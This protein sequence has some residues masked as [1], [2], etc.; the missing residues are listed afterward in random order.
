MAERRHL[1]PIPITPSRTGLIAIYL[2][3]AAVVARTLALEAIQPFLPWYLGLELIYVIL[4]T[5]LLWKPD[6]ALWLKHLYFVLQSLIVLLILAPRPQFDFVVVLFA[7]LSY[8]VSLSFAGRMRWIWVSCLVVLTGGS[9]IFYLG[10]LKGL[11]LALTTMAAEIVVPAHL[12]ASQDTEN[13][14]LKSQ[15]LLRD[16]Q[17]TNQQLQSFASQ[18]AE[19]A[20]IQ[21]RN[22]LARGLHD[23]VSQLIFSIALTSRSA[24]LLLEREPAR[25]PEQ[26]DRL[27]RMTTDALGQLRSFI[28]QLRPSQ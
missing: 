1:T 10:L 7:L 6:F 24:E 28:T 27:Q 22:R 9:L 25:V 16:L 20:V 18:V 19:L 21:E 26:L 15:R 11:A 23:T 14:R 13:A 3:Y 5:A 17:A 8:Q 4:F 2:I 12:I